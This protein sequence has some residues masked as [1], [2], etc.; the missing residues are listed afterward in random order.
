MGHFVKYS[1]WPG[2][3][4]HLLEA[5]SQDHL[6]AVY[7]LYG[8]SEGDRRF[9]A[10]KIVEFS[11]SKAHSLKISR[12]KGTENSFSEALAALNTLSLFGETPCV[13]FE[14]AEK[15][16]K[17][18][19][20][21]CEHYLLNP[22]LSSRLILCFSA[23]KGVGSDLYQAGKK[24]MVVLDL[25][26]EKPWERPQRLK[27][28]VSHQIKEA[29]KN[30]TPEAFAYLFEHLDPEMENFQQALDK[31]GCFVAE[32]VMIQKEDVEKLIQKKSQ[33]LNWHL[34]EALI[35]GSQKSPIEMPKDPG[36]LIFMIGALKFQIQIGQKLSVLLKKRATMDEIIAV[37]PQLRS[38][39][40]EKYLQSVKKFG[41]QFFTQASH[42][43]FEMEF[44]LKQSQGTPENLLQTFILKLE[45]LKKHHVR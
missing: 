40:M 11:A 29:S 45:V 14:E 36:A 13:I 12:F 39:Q 15:L 25:S 33:P 2:F 30:I 31:I 7:G 9:A 22:S 16:K 23:F 28:W 5:A 8:G 32:R 38:A 24:E 6:S 4:N 10:E 3:F 35:F 17:D 43:L 44:F 34:A 1:A 18:E 42:E 21:L 19:V 41:S 27:G 26:A 20:A 37:F